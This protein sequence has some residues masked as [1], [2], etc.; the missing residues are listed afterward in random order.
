MQWSHVKCKQCR[1]VISSFNFK[2]SATFVTLTRRYSARWV[3]EPQLKSCLAQSKCKTHKL[4]L[5]MCNVMF[6]MF[7]WLI[8]VS[9]YLAAFAV[10]LSHWTSNKDPSLMPTKPSDNK[11]NWRPFSFTSLFAFFFIN[12]FFAFLIIKTVTTLFL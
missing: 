7:S 11:S 10:P 6:L 5:V 9:E 1:I 12:I 8:I 4:L 3:L 2:F